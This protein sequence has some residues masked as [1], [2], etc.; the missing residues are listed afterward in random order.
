MKTLYVDENGIL[1]VLDRTISGRTPAWRRP[2]FW[3][4]TSSAAFGV[5]LWMF[6]ELLSLLVGGFFVVSGILLIT[7]SVSGRRRWRPW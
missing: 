1:H 5:L 3:V 4:G 2:A 6:P 7:W